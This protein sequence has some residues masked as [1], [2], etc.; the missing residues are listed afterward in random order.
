MIIALGEVIL[1]TTTAVDALVGR[2]GW[3]VDAVVVAVA[4]IALAVGVW[5]VYFAVP[6]GD[7]LHAYRTKGFGFGYG[8]MPL[9]AVIAAIGSGLHVVAYYVE[10]ESKLGA[11]GT[12]LA[13]ALPVALTV[14][15]IFLFANYLLPQ[16]ASFHRLLMLLVLGTLGVAVLLAAIGVPIALCLGVV[17]LSPWVAV[18]AYEVRG[19]QRL[20]QL[21][22]DAGVSAAHD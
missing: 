16:G 11:L 6:W 20:A 22:E 1:G 18:V 14:V 10:G 5:W 7:L 17:M 4:G 13:I 12:T 15:G 9:Y 2:A 3:T 21:L 8:H 19:H